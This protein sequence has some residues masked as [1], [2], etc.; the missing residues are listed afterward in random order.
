MTA[1]VLAALGVGLV[2]CAGTAL[3]RTRAY[4][5]GLIDVPNERSLHS[6]ATPRGGG[7]VVV[8]TVLTGLG[9][10]VI[11]GIGEAL[12]GV[13]VFA[14]A[15]A[16]VAG[17]GWRDDVRSLA[18]AVKFAAHFAAAIAAILTWGVFDRVQPPGTT[19]WSLPIAVA[20]P[21]TVVWLA[22]LLNAYN[23]M[24]GIDGLASGQAVIAGTVWMW[25]AGD[26]VPLVGWLGLLIAA[27]SAGFLCHNRPPA[28][29]FLG[30]AG[31][32][33]LGFAFAVLPLIAYAAT[34]D[35]RLPVAGA[36]VVWPFVF[37]TAFTLCRRLARGEN[38]VRAHRSH[39]YQRLVLGGWTHGKVTALYLAL[40]GLSAVASALWLEGRSGWILAA[41]L[42]ATALL[43][44][45]VGL[46]DRL[47]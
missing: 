46:K 26:A 47:A 28:R 5:W 30:D 16:L 15:A 10:L 43:V 13:M 29:I 25:V 11:G 8:A 6:Q 44:P 34:G 19:G 27:A 20:A 45:L 24:D 7:I 31:S 4:A 40:A 2:A 17:I 41:P 33:F 37:D 14:V 38:I 39:L 42:V 36:F 18:P 9:V 32:G 23:F 12:S 22:G 35:A 3:L 1:L 21:L